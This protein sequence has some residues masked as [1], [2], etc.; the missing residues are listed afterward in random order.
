MFI[1]RRWIWR[2]TTYSLLYF[3]VRAGDEFFHLLDHGFHSAL[4]LYQEVVC[5]L[6]SSFG[7]PVPENLICSLDIHSNDLG[8]QESDI[9]VQEVRQKFLRC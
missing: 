8:I 6:L 4:Y 5:P 9:W 1:F 2:R 7:S 3:D